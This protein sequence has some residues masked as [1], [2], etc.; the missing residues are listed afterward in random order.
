M[1]GKKRRDSIGQLNNHGFSLLELL[2]VMAIIVIVSTIT[3]VGLN[4]LAEGNAK[5]ANKTMYSKISE[6]RT[7]T[8][9]KSGEW[10]MVISCQDNTYTLETHHVANGEDNI[11]DT[12]KFSASRISLNYYNKNDGSCKSVKII[13]TEEFITDNLDS[14]QFGKI[15]ASVSRNNTYESKLWYKT[16]RVTT[17]N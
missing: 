17:Q 10:Y 4:V 6:L 15:V 11:K 2:V 5:K 12:S 8:M 3:A 9:S 1:S 7:T 14:P 16:G 13:D